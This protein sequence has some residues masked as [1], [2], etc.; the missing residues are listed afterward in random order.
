MSVDKRIVSL[1]FDNSKF[2]SKV[3]GSLSTLQ[4]LKK[5]LKLDK[6]SKGMEKL[7]Q[8]SRKFS[9]KNIEDGVNTVAKRFTNL[10]IVGTT[11]L[12]NLTNSAVNAGKR[13]VSALTIDPIK[14]GFQEY[15]TK[16]GAIQT[17]MTNTQS[18]GTTLDDVNRVLNELNEYSDKTIYNFAEMAK[19]IGTFTAAGIGLDESASA[20]KGIANLAAGSGSTSAQASTAMY[21][22]SQALAAGSV[23]LQ[24]WNSVVNA[25]MGG[26]LFQNA[27][28]D[29]AK[30]QGVFVDES[31]PFRES[32]HTGWISADILTKTL[33]KFAEDESLVKAATEVKTFTQL[34]DTMQESV[35]SGWAMSWEHIVGDKGQ[36]TEMLTN[37]SQ[38]FEKLIQPSTDARNAMLKF[39][40]ENGGRDAIISGIGKAFETL[41]SVLGPIKE[42]F[43][44]VF[45]AMTGERLVEISKKFESLMKN[46]KIEDGTLSNLK[47]TFKGFFAVLSIGKQL[48]VALTKPILQFVQSLLPAGSGILDL[49]GSFGD[50]LVSLD[51]AIKSTGIFTKIFEP[52]GNVLEFAGKGISGIVKGLAAFAKALGGSLLSGIKGVTN[53]LEPLK[54]L[55]ELIGKAF[56][57]IGEAL[58][59]VSPLFANLGNAILDGLGNVMSTVFEA[60]TN[61][62]YGSIGEA[63]MNGGILATILIAF[64]KF[65][66]SLGEFGGIGDILDTLKGSLEAY[67]QD[68]KAGTLIK[69]ATAIGILAASIAVLSLIDPARLTSALT[70]MGVMF[71]ELFGAMI[72]FEKVSS[73]PGFMA[74]AKISFGMIALSVSMGILAGALFVIS[75]LDWNG[76]AKGLTTVGILLLEI[77]L[78]MKATDLSGG[79]VR[80]SAGIVLLATALVI[81]S[82]AVKKFGSMDMSTLAKGLGAVAISLAQFAIFTKVMPKGKGLI[83]TAIGLTILATGMLILSKAIQSMGSMDIAT[84]A[85]GLLTM[86][87]AL[88]VIGVAIGL[89]PKGMILAG[90][91]LLVVSTAIV[92]LANALESMGNMSW[93]EIA[94]GLTMLAGTLTILTVAM[95]L[96]TAGIA[97]AAAMFIMAAAITALS[98]PLQMF[99]NM[100]LGEIGRSLL[101][102]AGAFTVIGVAGLVLTPLVPILLG[103][104]AGIALIGAGVALAGAGVALLATGLTALAVSGAAAGAGLVVFITSV[105]SI[106]PA[107][108][109]AF[110]EALIQ[111]VVII[112]EGAPAIVKA[113]A[114]IIEALIP[115]IMEL[116]PNVV[117]ALLTLLLALIEAIF[118]YIPKFVQAGVD[119]IV[120]LLEGLTANIGSIAKAGTDAMIAY[121]NAIGANVPRIV[122]AGLDLV[123]KLADGM[124]KALNSKTPQLEKSIQAL[125][126]AMI[127][128]AISIVTSPGKGAASIGKDMIRG[129]ISGIAS[130]KD[131]ALTAI[132]NLGSSMLT[133]MKSR[134]KI[135][136]PSRAFRDEVGKNIGEG[137]MVGL[138]KTKPKML[139]KTED[140]GSKSI[141]STVKGVKKATPKL[142]MAYSKAA[143]SSY[144][145]MKE[146][147]DKQK[148][149]H[150]I[151]LE[152]QLANWRK[153]QKIYKVGQDGY[154]EAML[155]IEKVED[156]K[157]KRSFNHSKDWIAKEKRLKRLSLLEEFEAWERV[158]VR[159]AKGTDERKEADRELFRVKEEIVA[160]MKQIDQDYKNSVKEVNTELKREID[161]LTNAYKQAVTDR[162]NAIA[163]SYGL[164]DKVE[165]DDDVSGEQLTKNLKDQV[166]V[167]K[168]W[169]FGVDTLKKK[170][171]ATGLV[172]ELRQLGPKS[173]A[174]IEALNNMTRKQLEQYSKLW[175]SKQKIARET[176]EKELIGLKKDTADQILDLRKNANK[177]LDKLNGDWKSEV[178]E[179]TKTTVDEYRQMGDDIIESLKTLKQK[180]VPQIT[181]NNREIQKAINDEDWKGLGTNIVSGITTGVRDEGAVSNLLSSMVYLAKTAKSSFEDELGIKSPS[182]VFMQIGRFIVDG[183][184]NGIDG[185]ESGSVISKTMKTLSD[186]LNT[187][188]DVN[189]VIRPVLDMTNVKTGMKN[190]NTTP[191][192]KLQN[193]ED[194]VQSIS[195]RLRVGTERDP[196]GKVNQE[197]TEINNHYHI[198]ATIREEA[199]IDKV[200]KKL[201]S[202]QQ[203]RSRGRG[204]IVYDR[205]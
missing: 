187:D 112:G 150:N 149:Y 89:M 155:E 3:Q 33:Q 142:K 74:M 96:M 173:Q 102:L 67:Q 184:S 63:L 159:Y 18:K 22:L 25:G 107:V 52:V 99:G 115:V 16:M 188:M 176:A 76:V 139:E 66:K 128:S 195:T 147:M 165:K 50:F 131:R 47:S 41:L 58:I 40:N 190:L 97:G 134:L 11:A 151:D 32:L 138:D 171:V 162:A 31:I 140:Y 160:K 95:N 174:Q 124:T 116:I 118:E 84:I 197:H 143:T 27:L 7:Q 101:M 55:G 15:E 48:F 164:F 179:L 193:Q 203:N 23:K 178:S 83:S 39:W 77:S 61:A 79:A 180:S 153:I 145:G 94:R 183:L 113:F 114:Q 129:V 121:L 185:R 133:A 104:G 34:Y 49:T 20:I 46:F 163:S 82:V 126:K 157:R 105:L 35:Q 172:E 158:Q 9:L 42:G 92:I 198:E 135:F 2:E 136:S 144:E 17:I 175:E 122:K 148:K 21:Q 170:G 192:V 202:L 56:S 68:L 154:Y 5:S 123:I 6:A 199:D 110:G 87:G 57:A 103:L 130:M 201:H 30:Q 141:E 53:G 28:K 75:R 91:G 98:I 117:E 109:T 137:I 182:R 51:E 168:Q 161:E 186:R 120:A 169:S 189:P 26:E 29:M 80:K 38:A 204:R 44:E 1:E 73:G 24:D 127:R 167:L 81:L 12:I 125:V 100:S 14:M 106:L 54:M 65:R 78:F 132:G 13:I 108:V 196:V 62:D 93:G 60:F 4:K 152:S 181:A 19:N 90:A 59:N 194:Q 166:D 111:I 36:S 45:P 205:V 156:E 70:A 119:L 64:K 69:I 8:T 43:R 88:T 85:K 177:E 71:A 191:T 86:A 146:W 72:L 37:I 10:G 200:S